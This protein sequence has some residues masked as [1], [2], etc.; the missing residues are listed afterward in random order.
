[1]YIFFT[2][3][4]E[5][6]FEGL[7]LSLFLYIASCIGSAFTKGKTAHLDMLFLGSIIFTLNFAQVIVGSSNL[8]YSHLH[9]FQY[10]TPNLTSIS[11]ITHS[12]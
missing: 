7:S 10:S 1:M 9:F 5:I 4:F 11:M 12:F 3:V 6:I 8:A 2:I